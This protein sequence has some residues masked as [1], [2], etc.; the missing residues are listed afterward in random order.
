MSQQ[1]AALPIDRVTPFK[2]PFTYVGVDCFGPFLV[3]LGRNSVVKRYGCL[4]TCLSIRAIHI[5]VL[6]SM[7]TDSFVNGL[8]RFI[9]RRGPPE[10]IRSDNGTN[11]HGGDRELRQS[12]REWNQEHIE[13]FLQQKEITWEYNPP[14]ASH[15]GGVWER[16]IRTVRKV[17]A[18]VLSEQPVHDEILSTMLC[19][20]EVRLKQTENGSRTETFARQTTSILRKC[21]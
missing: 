2:P 17:L 19:L 9:C 12:I 15:M 7:D 8:Q 10:K 14:A 5:E 4:F 6:Y 13:G 20:V 1:M 11:F 3:K 21:P 18:G 16:Q